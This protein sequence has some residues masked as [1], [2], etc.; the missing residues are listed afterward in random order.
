MPEG[1]MR[2]ALEAVIVKLM[3]GY[4]AQ[5][6]WYVRALGRFCRDQGPFAGF[7]EHGNC[8]TWPFAVQVTSVAPLM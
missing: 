5:R 4:W 3:V 2:R 7:T 8:C 6:G 1:S